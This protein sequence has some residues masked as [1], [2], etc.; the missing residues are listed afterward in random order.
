MSG[1]VALESANWDYATLG[2]GLKYAKAVAPKR[3]YDPARVAK[4]IAKMMEV[5]PTTWETEGTLFVIEINFAPQQSRFNEEEYKD[6]YQKALEISQT[7]GGA[8]VVIEGHA[9]PLGVLRARKE[10]KSLTFVAQMEQ[11]AKNLSLSRAD[12]VR[13][14]YLNFCQNAGIV[15]DDS[16]FTPVGRG[17]EAPKFNPP[18][19]KEEWA[20][21]RRVVFRIKQVEA[22]LDEFVPLD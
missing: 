16:Q 20:A 21:N 3:K 1:K 13:D 5:E 7:Y 10:G 14:S 22:E 12:A 15:I 19:T 17:V 11:A 6:D 9:D 8:I 18:R 4:E 2:E